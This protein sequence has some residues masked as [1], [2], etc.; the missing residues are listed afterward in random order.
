MSGLQILSV[1]ILFCEGAS[2]FLKVVAKELFTLKDIK[3][4][5]FLFPE[6]PYAKKPIAIK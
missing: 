6:Y 4:E 3:G 5:V 1:C 2:I